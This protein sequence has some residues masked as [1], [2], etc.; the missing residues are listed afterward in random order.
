MHFGLQA[1]SYGFFLFRSSEE[2]GDDA[3]AQVVIP[4]EG[5]VHYTIPFPRQFSISALVIR[6][7]VSRGVDFLIALEQ[8][9]NIKERNKRKSLPDP[10]SLFEINTSSRMRVTRVNAMRLLLV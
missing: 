6:E 2:R 7:I 5:P 10:G 3:A 9:D 4:T 1:S 8:Y